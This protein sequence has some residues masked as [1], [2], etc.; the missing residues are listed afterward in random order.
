MGGDRGVDGTPPS[1]GGCG[2]RGV[3]AY[4]GS[5]N[6]FKSPLNKRGVGI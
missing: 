6:A 1:W 5:T 2:D 4:E 3:F